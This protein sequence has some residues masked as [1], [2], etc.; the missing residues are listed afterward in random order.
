M[1]DK[2]TQPAMVVGLFPSRSEAERAVA[3]LKRGGF[4]AEQI[5]LVGKHDEGHV[6]NGN[7]AD[8]GMVTG[9][10]IGAGTAALVSLGLTFG[11]IPVIGPILA[12]GPLGAA[13]LSAAGGLGAGGLIGALIGLGVPEHEAKY[14][15]GEVKSG[16]FLVTV[17]A[18]DRAIEAWSVLHRVG[19]YNRETAVAAAR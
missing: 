14:Y 1:S 7:M 3:E 10:A 19:A 11:V 4:T 16:R 12:M 18:G 9:A 5:S 2:T 8:T 6:D 13:L 15:E 17:K